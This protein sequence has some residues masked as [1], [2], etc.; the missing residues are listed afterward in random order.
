MTTDVYMIY[1][2]VMVLYACSLP[3]LLYIIIEYIIKF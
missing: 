1:L 3:V 2:F